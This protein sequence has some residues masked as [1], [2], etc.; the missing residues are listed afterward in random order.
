M[1]RC[2]GH[3]CGYTYDPAKGVKRGKPAPETLSYSRLIHREANRV[4]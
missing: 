1:R 3:N 2:E 4:S